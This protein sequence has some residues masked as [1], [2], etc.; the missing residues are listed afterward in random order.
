MQWVETWPV[1]TSRTW[2]P[3]TLT[4][5]FDHAQTLAPEPGKGVIGLG[6]IV[7]ELGVTKTVVLGAAPTRT[8]Q[9][10]RGAMVVAGLGLGFVV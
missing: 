4:I 10:A 9:W 3:K 7:G 6:T 1:S 8:V 5:H 2:V